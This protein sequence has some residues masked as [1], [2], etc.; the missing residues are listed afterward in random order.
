ML[1]HDM[2]TR[3]MVVGCRER[4]SCSSCGPDCR[5]SRAASQAGSLSRSCRGLT[6]ERVPFSQRPQRAQM[7]LALKELP[8]ATLGGAWGQRPGGAELAWLRGEALPAC[9]PVLRVSLLPTVRH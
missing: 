9:P 2:R 1:H 7:Y 6:V 3:M 8:R 5:G 4:F